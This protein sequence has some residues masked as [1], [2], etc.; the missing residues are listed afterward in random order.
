MKIKSR[1]TED[2]ISGLS[3]ALAFP[4]SITKA[5]SLNNEDDPVSVAVY[6]E[7]EVPLF[8]PKDMMRQDGI[9]TFAIYRHSMHSP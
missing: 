5:S 8:I 6:A 7:L 1:G 9:K 4:D 2:D 3:D